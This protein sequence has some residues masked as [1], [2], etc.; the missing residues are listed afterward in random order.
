[1]HTKNS[2]SIRSEKQLSISSEKTWVVLHVNTEIYTTPI[3]G[4]NNCNFNKLV[5]AKKSMQKNETS[6]ISKA[7]NNVC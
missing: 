5:K 3:R 6:S 4:R 7:G 1:M 2:Q